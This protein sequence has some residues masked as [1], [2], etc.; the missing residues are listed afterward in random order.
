MVYVAESG[1]KANRV[2]R[3]AIMDQDGANVQY[4]TE[5][6][7]LALTPRFSPNNDMV[8]YMNFDDGNPQVYLLQLSTGQPAAAGLA[9]GR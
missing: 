8:T 5:G 3:L 1:P 7:S 4:L 2:K 6:R 9:G